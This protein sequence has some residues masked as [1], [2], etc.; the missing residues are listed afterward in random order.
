MHVTLNVLLDSAH[1]RFGHAFMLSHLTPVPPDIQIHAYV[2]PLGRS[3]CLTEWIVVG[4]TGKRSDVI[5]ASSSAA[6]VYI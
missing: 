4:L 2:S 1:I 3:F 6:L 5:Q